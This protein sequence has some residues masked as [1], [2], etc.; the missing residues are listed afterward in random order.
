MNNRKVL[1]FHV[2]KEKEKRISDLCKELS[3]ELLSIPKEK[4]GEILGALAGVSGMKLSGKPYEGQE[5]P[6]EM[7]I[8]SGLDSKNLGTFLD[9]YRTEKISPIPL[10]A[11]LTPYNVKWA[12]NELYMEL[13]KEHAQFQK[14]GTTE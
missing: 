7:M 12:A 1:L 14:M 11:T 6:S 4:Y 10:K 2:E 8:L 13:V 5:F 3:I 9:R